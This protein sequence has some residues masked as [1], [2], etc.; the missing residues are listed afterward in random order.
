MGQPTQQNSG[1]RAPAEKRAMPQQRSSWWLVST[2][3]TN[4]LGWHEWLRTKG[5]RE[6]NGGQGV[7]RMQK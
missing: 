7:E 3:C 1:P 6:E 5:G 4:R 2:G